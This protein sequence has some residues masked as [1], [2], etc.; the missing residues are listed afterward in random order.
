MAD[1][2]D[3]FSDE[4]RARSSASEVEE[5]QEGD[6][7]DLQPNENQGPRAGARRLPLAAGRQRAREQR[8]VGAAAAGIRVGA[9]AGAVA[10][11]AAAGGAAVGAE[12]LYEPQFDEEGQDL[13]E[14]EVKDE[15]AS[16]NEE[17]EEAPREARRARRL[18][19]LQRER[20]RRDAAEPILTVPCLAVLVTRMPR[21]ATQETKIAYTE[22]KSEPVVIVDWRAGPGDG[23]IT[24]HP[25]GKLY[26]IP[27]SDF[28]EYTTKADEVPAELDGKDNQDARDA[29][30]TLQSASAYRKATEG[31]VVEEE[32]EGGEVKEVVKRRLPLYSNVPAGLRMFSDRRGKYVDATNTFKQIY[33]VGPFPAPRGQRSKVKL[34]GYHLRFWRQGRAQLYTERAG[35]VGAGPIDTS[36][37]MSEALIRQILAL[38]DEVELQTWHA[39][40][41]YRALYRAECK[42][43]NIGEVCDLNLNEREQLERTE[44]NLEDAERPESLFDR[45][46]AEGLTLAAILNY[47]RENTLRNWQARDVPLA[48][49]AL[50]SEQFFTDEVQGP[51][52]TSVVGFRNFIEEN[53]LTAIDE[54]RLEEERA[55]DAA[56]AA[57]QAPLPE[58][59]V[60]RR[61]FS[62]YGIDGLTQ[63]TDGPLIIWHPPEAY[64]GGQGG[65]GEGGGGGGGGD[66]GG[67]G[68][69]E[70]GGEEERLNERNSLAE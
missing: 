22:H 43:L 44:G 11:P 56:A 6:L 5:D 51:D 14:A 57:G 61:N 60:A 46:K 18:R 55:Q 65:E 40:K 38:P 7:A 16:E 48:R 29:W 31:E 35:G 9:G 66:G 36:G 39:W 24:H 52:Q 50:I 21:D 8:R 17:E 53:V 3:E 49:E 15:A 27:L 32:G 37:H 54:A 63:P 64:A 62:P 23:P 58:S 70:E 42:T 10:A 33:P 47:A 26:Y 59:A 20:R 19:T 69:Q 30:D 2:G 1:E 34:G 41:I 68:G 4:G 67:G 12:D 28:T 13:D 45:A 25:K